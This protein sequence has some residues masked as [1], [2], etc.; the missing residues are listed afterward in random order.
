MTPTLLSYLRM[1]ALESKFS[2]NQIAPCDRTPNDI[3][4]DS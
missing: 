2:S 1:E 4:I 3:I